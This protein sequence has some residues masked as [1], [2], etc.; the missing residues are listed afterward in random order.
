VYCI[1]LHRHGVS[2]YLGKGGRIVTSAIFG[3][4]FASTLV[5][6]RDD[7]PIR[8]FN[9][10]SP[11]SLSHYDKLRTQRSLVRGV[12]REAEWLPFPPRWLVRLRIVLCAYFGDLPLS[13]CAQSSSQIDASISLYNLTSFRWLDRPASI[14][15]LPSRYCNLCSEV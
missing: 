7:T 11:A 10:S 8:L 13:D 15:C 6:Q 1:A 5:L 9:F 12:T 3:I 14:A 2:W 4:C